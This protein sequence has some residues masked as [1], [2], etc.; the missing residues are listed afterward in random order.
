MLKC[1]WFH[2]I[3]PDIQAQTKDK[4]D[5]TKNNIYGELESIFHKFPKYHMNILLGDFNTK[6]GRKDIF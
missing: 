4:T 1:R 6:V 2:I 5:H 3:V